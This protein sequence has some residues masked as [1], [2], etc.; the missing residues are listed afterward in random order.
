M[1]YS[2]LQGHIPDRVFN[3]LSI[4]CPKFQID[5]PK[6]LSNLLGQAHHESG[7]FTQVYENLNYS[8][9]GLANTWPTRYAVDSR[10]TQKVPNELAKKIQ[11]QP[12]AI[13]NHTYANRMGNGPVESGDGWKHRGMGFIQTTGKKN[14]QAFFR[15][16]ELPADSDPALIAT[17]YPLAS[18]AFFFMNNV[19]WSLCDQGTDAATIERITR[20]VNGGILGLDERIRHTQ[21]Y[22]RLMTTS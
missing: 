13:A 10:A 22:Y 4:V 21:E 8:A 7:G 3:E 1:F 18:A 16:I 2:K 9:Q 6:R 12:E 19:K 5:G 15:Y 17:T 11:R 20:K 14:Q